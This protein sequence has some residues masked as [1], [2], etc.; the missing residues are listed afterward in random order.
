MISEGAQAVISYMAPTKALAKQTAWMCRRCRKPN[1]MTTK[2]FLNHLLR[3]NGEEL[4]HI[5]PKFNSSQKLTVD[6]ITDIILHGIPRRWSREFERTGFDPMESS[7]QALM[8]QCERME[9]LDFMDGEQTTKKT[10]TQDLNKSSKKSHKKHKVSHEKSGG[11]CVIHGKGCGHRTDDC[12]VVLGMADPNRKSDKKVSF[13]KDGK[14][15]H[16]NK[17]WSRK[18]DEAKN[19]T[20]KDLAAFIGKM[21]K[22]EL[23]AVQKTD[24]KCK[25]SDDDDDDDD[26]VNS[27][28]AFNLSVINFTD[29]A[30]LSIQEEAQVSNSEQI[31][32]DDEEFIVSS[33][34]RAEKDV[35]DIDID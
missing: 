20:K 19:K 2:V 27:V 18:L 12:K 7:L 6:D 9:S 17:S 29:M 13:K 24:D 15:H 11:D 31:R 8:E 25:K 5:P 21:V 1:D 23:N 22:K 30:N 16:T 26:E 4:P 34:E 35:I 14:K 33:P 3:I 32:R 28:N 10:D